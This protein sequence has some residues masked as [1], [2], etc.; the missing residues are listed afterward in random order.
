[1]A[2]FTTLALLALAGGLAAYDAKKLTRSSSTGD[3]TSTTGQA[4][5]PHQ[6][7]A[8]AP[9]PSLIAPPPAPPDAG[10]AASTAAGAAQQ[11]AAKQRRR[12][13]AGV[14][15]PPPATL[16]TATP[17]LQPKTLLGGY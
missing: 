2:A 16:A 9:P 8:T 1:M 12:A 3:A 13:G 6:K 7:L 14:V 15:T 5:L 17:V 11:A 4:Q 10:L